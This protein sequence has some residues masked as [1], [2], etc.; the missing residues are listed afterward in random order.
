MVMVPVRF[1]PELV[2][3]AEMD[4]RQEEASDPVVLLQDARNILFEDEIVIELPLW[5]YVPD[6]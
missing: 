4:P 1:D 5:V 3:L 2:K 6:A